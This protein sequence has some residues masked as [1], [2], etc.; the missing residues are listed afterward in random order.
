M[1]YRVCSL[2]FIYV[3]NWIHSPAAT[4]AMRNIKK[5]LSSAV[6]NLSDKTYDKS[7]AYFGL[8]FGITQ[9]HS[10]IP[11]DLIFDTIPVYR[12]EGPHS[13]GL[14]SRFC[15]RILQE[16]FDNDLFAACCGSSSPPEYFY[17]DVNLIAHCANLGYIEEH[18]IR[19]HILQ[20]LIYHSK[21]YDHH[22]IGLAILFRIAGA[23]FGAYVNSAVVDNCLELLKNHQL[24]SE[25]WGAPIQVSI[26]SGE[27]FKKL[28][29]NSR[30]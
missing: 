27:M 6:S 1:K 2:S 17:A 21:V 9:T 5:A 29:Q 19:N 3:I 25:A 4:I 8:W 26:L 23:T 16:F 14:R 7:F 15:A 13:T 11:S 24:Q 30:R 28:R 18:T 22:I 20:S 10:K 12:A